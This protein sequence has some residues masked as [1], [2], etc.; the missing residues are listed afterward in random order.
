MDSP[1]VRGAETAVA[2]G[3]TGYG[4]GRCLTVTVLLLSTLFFYPVSND[5]AYAF[6]LK[7]ERSC[8]IHLRAA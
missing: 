6:H 5:T 7:K 4:R 2:V 1:A 3:T 8:S